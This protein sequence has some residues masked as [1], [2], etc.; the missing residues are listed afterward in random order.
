LV[1]RSTFWDE[2]VRH[3]GIEQA[4]VLGASLIVIQFLK[5]KLFKLTHYQF[6]QR[7]YAGVPMGK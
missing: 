7:R 5:S 6:F 1:S 3:N 4:I 2:R